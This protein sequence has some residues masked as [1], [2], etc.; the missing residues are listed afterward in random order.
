MKFQTFF[1]WSNRA[2]IY[3]AAER[4]NAEIV[5]LLLEKP[6]LDINIKSTIYY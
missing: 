1:Y 6:E 5:K 3:I 2:S 4:G